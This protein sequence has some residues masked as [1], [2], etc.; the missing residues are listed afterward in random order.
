MYKKSAFLVCLKTEHSAHYHFL[1]KKGQL[2]VGDTKIRGFIH[3]Q[4]SLLYFFP[5]YH[6]YPCVIFQI[7]ADPCQ[8]LEVLQAALYL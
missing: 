5:Y 4:S 2:L 6:S 8:W 1:Y 3:G 7:Q